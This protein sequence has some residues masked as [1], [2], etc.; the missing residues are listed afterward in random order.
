MRGA[1]RPEIK[2]SAGLGGMGPAGEYLEPWERF[3]AHLREVVFARQYVHH[4]VDVWHS[5]DLM[6]AGFV[7]IT[8]YHKGL[9][10]RLR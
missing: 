4:S 9:F 10:T 7:Q 2:S 1:R 6:Q 8:I 3:R 5:E